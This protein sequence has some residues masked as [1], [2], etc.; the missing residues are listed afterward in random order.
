MGQRV[1][2]QYSVEIEDLEAEVNRLFKA[3]MRNL[4]FKS[5]M[6][7]LSLGTEG[8]DQVDNLRRKLAKADIMLGDVQ[9]IIQGYVRFKTQPTDIEK[10]E[11]EQSS[12][13]LELEQLQ[14]RISQFKELMNAQPDQ[15]SEKA[16]Q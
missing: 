14:D 7:Q 10:Q 4:D 13:E 16:D 6:G 8:M 1:N 11:L 9:N 5:P 15:E 3:A 2:I 12:D